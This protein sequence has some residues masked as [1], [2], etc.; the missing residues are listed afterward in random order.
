[1]LILFKFITTRD[2]SLRQ[3]TNVDEIAKFIVL[4]EI[5]WIWSSATKEFMISFI[6]LLFL[7]DM[8]YEDCLNS[9]IFFSSRNETSISISSLNWSRSDLKRNLWLIKTE[10]MFFLYF[11][12]QWSLMSEF[13]F[14]SFSDVSK[15]K[16]FVE[17]T[18][19]STLRL[20]RFLIF[21]KIERFE[22]IS[23]FLISTSD[24]FK[25]TLVTFMSIEK[26]EIIS[27]FLI[28]TSDCFKRILITFIFISMK[29]SMQ[30]YVKVFKN[31]STF[32]F[33][34]A[35]SKFVKNTLI[36]SSKIIAFI[37]VVKEFVSESS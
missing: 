10:R 30:S 13:K 21:K 36:I 28:S 4:N 25:R 3:I 27:F 22:I 8:K 18:F 9:S 6:A 20:K 14:F 32:I 15:M 12:F 23:S 11:D 24:F 34:E 29:S 1:M 31:C 2:F 35:S 26:C 5:F 7:I 37:F 16:E 33:T 17:F 19:E